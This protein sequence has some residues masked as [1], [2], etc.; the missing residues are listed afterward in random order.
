MK[1]SRS[2]ETSGNCVEIA[3]GIPDFVPVGDTKAPHSPA[4]I[5]SRTAWT[6]FVTGVKDGGFPV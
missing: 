2:A 4:L 1:S 3:P 6:A 5:T